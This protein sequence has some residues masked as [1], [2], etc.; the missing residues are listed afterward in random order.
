MIRVGI[1]TASDKGSKG[2]R[3]DESGQVIKEIVAEI[4]GEVVSYQIV[5]DE[6]EELKEVMLK[7]I[8]KENVEL[9]LTTG[10]TGLGP[11]D[12]TPDATLELIEKEVP[13]LAEAMRMESLKVTNRA[14]LSRA[15]SGILQESLIVNLPGSPKAV[16][17]CLEVILPA[18]PHAIELIRG[19]VGDCAR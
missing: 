3:E 13:G 1:I 17:E 5:P 2:E 12:V 10:G 14:M 7:M 8:N 9:L 19:E 4:N 15:V 16:S 11:R 18:I 6:K